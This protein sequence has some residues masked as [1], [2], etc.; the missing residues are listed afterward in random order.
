MCISVWMDPAGKS[1]AGIDPARRRIGRQDPCGGSSCKTDLVVPVRRK[2]GMEIH[3]PRRAFHG[4]ASAC[5]LRALADGTGAGRGRPGSKH[6]RVPSLWSSRRLV[7]ERRSAAKSEN[8]FIPA[9]EQTDLGPPVPDR[10]AAEVGPPRNHGSTLRSCAGL[11]RNRPD[12]RSL[13]GITDGALFAPLS[14]RYIV[15]I[16]LD[17]ADGPWPSCAPFA[18]RRSDHE[19]V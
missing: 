3:R 13:P 16:G 19:P 4:R 2:I 5:G 17:S 15:L 6:P 1:G 8:R 12:R 11:F 7:G 9:A 14:A 10:V 18:T